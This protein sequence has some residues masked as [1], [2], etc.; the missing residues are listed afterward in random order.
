MTPRISDHYSQ[1][2][3]SPEGLQLQ[4][5]LPRPLSFGLVGDPLPLQLPPGLLLQTLG[6]VSRRC[7]LGVGGD[8]DGQLDALLQGVPRPLVH[9]L[10]RLDV[11]TAD[12]QVV[13]AEAEAGSDRQLLIEAEH[14]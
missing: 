2:S 1:Y 12:H 8:L 13:L 6:L 11:Y 14:G 4:Q 5:L 9:R 3:Q 7:L 10:H